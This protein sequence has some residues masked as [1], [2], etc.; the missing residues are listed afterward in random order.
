MRER[1]I[2]MG[3]RGGKGKGEEKRGTAT[4]K[5]MGK[6][7]E[8]NVGASSTI[9][10]TDD[11]W[12]QGAE[13][14]PRVV[15]EVPVWIN[16]NPQDVEEEI[17]PE[18][19]RTYEELLKRWMEST[20][21]ENAD[22][23]E[24]SDD[25]SEPSVEEIGPEEF[26]RMRA[27][28]KGKQPIRDEDATDEEP[29]EGSGGKRPGQPESEVKDPICSLY[30]DGTYI[31]HK[32]AG[33]LIGVVDRIGERVKLEWT[34]SYASVWIR[35]VGNWICYPKPGTQDEDVNVVDD[36]APVS[37]VLARP[38]A[39]LGKHVAANLK[40]QELHYQS[41]G[42][43][44]KLAKMDELATEKMRMSYVNTDLRFVLQ[45]DQ[46]Q[47]E[48]VNHEV[49]PGQ[50]GLNSG[51]LTFQDAMELITSAIVNNSSRPRT[52]ALTPVVIRRVMARLDQI[53]QMQSPMRRLKAC[54]ELRKSLRELEG[55]PDYIGDLHEELYTLA[56]LDVPDPAWQQDPVIATSPSSASTEGELWLDER[57]DYPPT[58]PD[59]NPSWSDA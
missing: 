18:R 34:Q 21:R 58:S 16:P 37:M 24:S 9:P 35:R 42:W 10:N 48:N 29:T 49:D 7:N 43:K 26:D 31:A 19:L 30:R 32:E 40:I 11:A 46:D 8:D 57:D 41:E 2:E 54:G 59:Q 52:P 20:P 28:G 15:E 44:R 45:A 5:K 33:L 53:D 55:V 22:W 56:L 27:K 4:R 13:Q 36:E 39:T 47:T 1:E 17:D 3:K 50:G 23:S 38:T 6:R 12:E 14:N 51:P 25:E